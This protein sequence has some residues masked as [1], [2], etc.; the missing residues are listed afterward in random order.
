MSAFVLILAALASRIAA[1]SG[2]FNF[3][4]TLTGFSGSPTQTTN[5]FAVVG[6][7]C[8]FNILSISGTSSSTAFTVSLPIT[9]QQSASSSGRVTDNGTVQANPGRIDIV[10]G[11]DAT[12]A[13]VRLNWGGTAFT[14]SGTKALGGG[15]GTMLIYEI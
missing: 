15:V 14:G 11:T 4:A 12:V 1:L 3:T 7:T 6:R 8:F 9:A 13:N 2:W 10:V 5:R